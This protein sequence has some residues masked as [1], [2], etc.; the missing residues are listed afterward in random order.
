MTPKIILRCVFVSVLILLSSCSTAPTVKSNS[1]FEIAYLRLTDGYWQVWATDTAGSEHIQLTRS[2]VDKTRVS[3]SPKKQRLLCNQNDGKLFTLSLA[4][5]ETPLNLSVFGMLDAAWS[6]A[7]DRIAFSLNAT[8][9]TDNNDLWVMNGDGSAARKLTNQPGVVQSPSW[10]PDGKQLA[11]AVG[12]ARNHVDIWRFDLKSGSREQLTVPGKRYF[13]PSYTPQGDLL[14]SV[15]GHSNF[16]VVQQAERGQSIRLT[17]HAAYDSDPSASPTGRRIAF[18][19]L[20]DGNKRI[21]ILNRN[22]GVSLPITPANAQSRY[23]VW[24]QR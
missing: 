10:H 15:E 11:Y 7:G 13:G 14:Y 20:R 24:M 18:Y 22:T 3:W 8:Q 1:Q 19:S 6:R 16:D 4:G 9:T 5:E 12:A 21:W 17:T 2:P 23:P